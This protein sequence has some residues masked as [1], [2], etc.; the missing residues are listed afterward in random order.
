MRSGVFFQNYAAEEQLWDSPAARYWMVAFV[1]ILA[2]FP[3][4]ASDYLI[5]IACIIG[6]HVIATLGLN[7]TTGNTGLISLAHAAFL[8]VGAY[9]AAWLSKQG[10]PFYLVLPLAG[11]TAAATGIV[12]GLPSLRV[13]GLYLAIATLAAHFVL[14]FIFRE[15]RAVTGGF[16]GTNVVSP[17]LFG[18]DLGGDRRIYYIIMIC[19]LVVGIA[20]R[21]LFRTH[22]GRALIAVRDRD[23]SAAV[24]GVNLLK[25]K[26]TAFAL[27]A[28]YAGIAGALLGYY[29]GAVNPEYFSLTLAIFYLAATIVGGLGRILGSVLGATFMAFV[30]EALRLGTHVLSQWVPS[31]A[32]IVLP[33]GQVVFGALIILFLVCEP[34]GLAEIWARVRRFFH[35][36][37]FKTS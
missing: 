8:G 27:G 5:A 1:A 14:T 37:P 12:T 19:A 21:N 11:L 32:K 30:P 17:S 16:G 22:I 7:I 26:L 4:V 28:F 29:Y 13:K 3:L 33:M 9:S 36:W 18:F 2:L 10:V 20:T 31:A 35:L 24:I 25:A 6:I 15:W 34:H 23:I